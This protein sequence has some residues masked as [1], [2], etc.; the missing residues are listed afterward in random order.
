MDSQI[1]K[2]GK[3]ELLEALRNRYRS[4]TKTEKTRI[5]DEFSAICGYHRKDDQAWV[6][7]KNGP[8]VRRLV[9]HARF[10]G[11]LAG[12]ALA[13]LYQSARLHVNYFQA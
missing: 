13:H 4:S 2:E 12:Q 5:L 1:S 9:G 3:K 6:E 8:V 11:V 7:Q 10:S